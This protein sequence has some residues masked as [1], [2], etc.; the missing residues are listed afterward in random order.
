M[1]G[2]KFSTFSLIPLFSISQ[3]FLRKLS[4]KRRQWAI[5]YFSLKGDLIENYINGF[6]KAM[7]S[8][9]SDS[10]IQKRLLPFLGD[11]NYLTPAILEFVDVESLIAYWYYPT[12]LPVY[13]RY[14]VQKDSSSLLPTKLSLSL[15][16]YSSSIIVYSIALDRALDLDL[17]LDRALAL[18]LARAL[19]RALDL[20]LDLA[21]LGLW[22]WLW[23]GLWIEYRHK[24]KN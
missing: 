20:A 5:T 16:S 6:E 17:A 19:T 13:Y 22:I 24:W 18:D 12:F 3:T 8:Y 10:D 4:D 21:W 11:F 15:F 23:L 14:M 7:E 2:C 9:I 1:G